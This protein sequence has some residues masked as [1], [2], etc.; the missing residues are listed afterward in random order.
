MSFTGF[1][2]L[3]SDGEVGETGA[4]AIKQEQDS[5]QSTSPRKVYSKAKQIEHQ[6]PNMRSTTLENRSSSAL[7]GGQCVENRSSSALI[8]GCILDQGDSPADGSSI[9]SAS[10][11]C[12]VPLYRQFWKAGNYNIKQSSEALPRSG[13]NHLRVHPKF[14]HSNAT[15]HKWAF[16]AIAEL[17]D[18]AID[19]IENGA[20]F[21]I[22]DQISNSRDGTPAF[23][24]QDDGGGMDPDTMR[25]CLSFGFS[26]KKSK[27]AIGQYGNGFKTSTMRLGADAIVFSRHMSERATTQSIGL[28]SYTFL[29]QMG[30]DK[31]VVP[32]VDYEFNP[33]TETFG[34][35]PRYGVEH[36]TSNLSI[37]RQWSPYATEAELLS[38]FEDVGRHGTKVIIYNLWLND[39]GDMELDF[40]S[41]P[42]DILIRGEQKKVQEHTQLSRRIAEQHIANRF[43]YSL[44]VYSSILYLRIPQSFRIILRGRVVVHHNIAHDL[45]FPECILYKPQIGGIVEAAILTT[46]GFLKDAPHVNVH[47]F[48]VYHKNRLI[49]PFWR[50]VS[51]SNSFGRGVVGILEAN[52]IEPTHDKQD[53]EKTSLFQ[54]LEYRLKQMTLEYWHVHCGLIGYFQVKKSPVPVIPG[55]SPQSRTHGLQTAVTNHGSPAVD[56]PRVASA[57]GA[58]LGPVENLSHLLVGKPGLAIKRKDHGHMVEQERMKARA[59]SGENVIDTRQNK[60]TQHE[61]YV[62]SQVQEQEKIILMQENKKLRAQCSEYKRRTEQ[63]N[64]KVQQLRIELDGVQ[65]EYARLLAESQAMD[66]V[67]V[68]NR[69]ACWAKKQ[70]LPP[71][72]LESRKYRGIP[73]LTSPWQLG[74][75]RVELRTFAS[76]GIL[77]GVEL[78][79]VLGHVT[80]SV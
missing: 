39:D 58:P 48:N 56:N 54:K 79:S 72:G 18:N 16:G 44:R 37:L 68:E 46:I 71:P 49:L 61:N 24:I 11:G 8:A 65:C 34:I 6:K 5:V 80:Y 57:G 9:S 41:D 29:R 21:V 76:L 33:S 28:L 25:Q 63:L 67:K 4:K 60:V 75:R 59:R 73:S 69:F 2:H 43:H 66:A 7:N 1:L 55:G 15:S 10:P 74:Q 32:M 30:Y 17:L 23:L 78:R 51:Q 31:I 20:T 40:E 14:L 27:S 13:K 38:Q 53:F 45:R 35:L 50:V 70:E 12:S 36:F 52:F 62:E 3:S 77:L 47:G 42:Q 26:D 64:L 19:E 22:V